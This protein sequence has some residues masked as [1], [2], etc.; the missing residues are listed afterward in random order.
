MPTT[1][2]RN[3]NIEWLRARLYFPL[4]MFVSALADFPIT[5]R[6]IRA[7]MALVT[8]SVC[9][10]LVGKKPSSVSAVSDP[11]WCLNGATSGCCACSGLCAP[12]FIFFDPLDVPLLAT[13]VTVTSSMWLAGDESLRLLE[14]AE[15]ED[16]VHA[17]ISI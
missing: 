12:F 14:I 5:R 8:T 17:D 11:K 7:W 4:I 6:M 3:A 10:N 1:C 2:F 9:A 16:I 13:E 15:I